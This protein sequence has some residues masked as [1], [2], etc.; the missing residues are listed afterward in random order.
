[1]SRFLAAVKLSRFWSALGL[2]LTLHAAAI[3]E[4]VSGTASTVAEV[5]PAILEHDSTTSGA[6][7]AVSPAEALTLPVEIEPESKAA[8]HA[9]DSERPLPPIVRAALPTPQKNDPRPLATKS[10]SSPA[11]RVAA[12]SPS[13][14]PSERGDA[15]DAGPTPAQ[16]NESPTAAPAIDRDSL[17]RAMHAAATNPNQGASTFTAVALRVDPQERNLDRAFARAFAWAF[18]VDRSFFSR[19][20]VGKAKFVIELGE[21]GRIQGVSW[22]EPRAPSRLMELVARMVKLLSANRFGLPGSDEE[23]PKQR[24]FEMRVNQSQTSVP[25]GASTVDGQEGELWMLDAGET[26]T[27]G[28]P[29]HPAVA[30]MTGHRIDCQLSILV[31]IPRMP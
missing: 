31:P 14:R 28:R 15:D 10:G 18:A 4:F 3:G 12:G 24:A 11:D 21:D 27:I 23:S 22:A 17:H 7:A 2:S 29:S 5:P 25:N 9:P 16:S 30:D 20:P 8:P 26:P 1:V 13:S 6:P 19:V